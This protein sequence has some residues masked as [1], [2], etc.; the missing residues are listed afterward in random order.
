[1]THRLTTNYAK[2]YCNRTLI[3]KVILENV[4]TCFFGTRCRFTRLR[5]CRAQEANWPSSRDKVN[6]TD[7]RPQRGCNIQHLL[8]GRDRYL[9]AVVTGR[10]KD[11]SR[12]N[13]IQASAASLSLYPSLNSNNVSMS[14]L[15]V[16]VDS[17]Y[18]VQAVIC[19]ADLKTFKGIC[20]TETFNINY[21]VSD[22]YTPILFL[23]RDAL[24]AIACRLSVCPS[25]CPS[26]TLVNCDHIG[27]NSSKTISPLV[28]MGRSLFATL[29]YRVC[30]KGN[31]PKIW[32][33][34]HSP[35][36]DLGVGD[37]RSQIVAEWLQSATVTIESL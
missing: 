23:P 29:T 21:L 2:N 31:T 6:L 35:P 37:I 16:P 17:V 7:Q 3:V 1:M 33:Q 25:V 30:S 8:H 20:Y 27:W 14:R 28:S 26:V 22:E 18:T 5:I 34:S 11:T 9:S 19:I 10:Y 15:S 13:I 4:V 32:A 12:S 36:V 24:I